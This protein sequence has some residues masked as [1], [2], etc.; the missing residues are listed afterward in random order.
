MRWTLAHLVATLAQDVSRSQKF[1]GWPQVESTPRA[2]PEVDW[3]QVGHTPG[4]I[5]GTG[6]VIEMKPG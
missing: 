6:G 3:P 2:S 1:R 5:W 4:F